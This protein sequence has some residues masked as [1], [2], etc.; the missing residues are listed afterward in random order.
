MPMRRLAG[1][2]LSVVLAVTGLLL[3]FQAVRAA[4]AFS[5]QPR[6]V[7][8]SGSGIQCHQLAPCALPIALFLANPGDT[9][10]L[11]QGT[12]TGSGAAVITVTVSI[13]LFGGWSGNPTGRPMVDPA[14]YPTRIDGEGSRRGIFIGSGITP[15]VDGLVIQNG[16]ATGLVAGCSLYNAAGCG[17]GIFVDHAAA[18]ILNNTFFGN[19]ALITTTDLV[20]GY[21]GG[22]LLEWADGSVISGNVFLKNSASR[23]LTQT[24]GSGGGMAITGPNPNSVFVQNNMFNANFA[25]WG[26]GWRLRRPKTAG[27]NRARF[28]RLS[29]SWPRC[30]VA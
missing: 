30:H 10:Y 21:G 17:G 4:T 8:T 22:L 9:L 16:N 11:E 6:F 28:P 19:A 2:C 23:L 26:V 7:S 25:Y 12:Y 1:R 24:V 13:T 18:Q 20:E 27:S 3:A 14:A 5:S 15:T 29:R